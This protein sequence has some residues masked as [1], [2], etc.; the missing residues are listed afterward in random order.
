MKGIFIVLA[1]CWSQLVSAQPAYFGG[2]NSTNVTVTAS[3]SFQDPNWPKSA[4]PQ[5][6][7]NAQGMLAAYFNAA[8][9]LHQTTLGFDSTHVLEVLNLGFTGWINDQ[10]NK[11]IEK[12][13][14]R[15]LNIFDIIA[16]T[17]T[18][19]GL[20][21]EIGRRPGWKE[22]NYAWWDVNMQNNDLLRQRVAAALSEILVISRNSDLE[23]YG[24]GLASFYDILL[25]HAF[26]NYRD[27]LYDVTLH[28]AMGFYLSHLDNPKTDESTGT[29]PDENYARE[30]MQ[31]FSIGLYQLNIDGTRVV[32]NGSE[33]PTY[34]NDDISEFAKVF[35][36][37]GVGDLK[38]DIA[39]YN[40]TAAFGI[41]IYEADMTVPMR[42]YDVDDPGTSWRDED[43]HEEGPK[44]LLNN[45]TVPDGQTGL[46]DINDAI[47]NLFNHSN[48]GPFLAYRLIQRLV[49]S[50]PTPAYVQ[51]VASAFNGTGP[52]GTVR[53]D[54]KS[55]VKAILLDT[56]ARDA[57]WQLDD[58][59]GKL[60]E[61]LIRYTHFARAVEKYNANGFYWNIGYGF[62]E[63]TKQA[64]LASPSVFNFF[65]P[66]DTPNGD[67]ADQGL[68]A[69]EF[70]I[71]D[72]RTS[73]GFANNVYVWAA[74]W[75][76][77]MGT[78]EGEIMTH[79]DVDWVIDDLLEL[80][81]D[82][83]SYIN[84]LDK[85]LH[86]GLMSDRTRGILRNA[87]NSFKS[88][89][90]WHNYQENRVRMG[91][92]LALMAPEYSIMR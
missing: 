35:T 25:E 8:R 40:D 27:L 1:I 55:V 72:S 75:G 26:G 33:V 85:H 17:L 44:Y 87:L 3:S 88:T 15:T 9:F 4:I 31:L 6:T 91:L 22:F 39:M 67:I 12:M 54:M 71:H 11:P 61:P 48:V 68:V 23:G 86:S 70:K 7:V 24:D 34:D 84:W 65:L 47:D 92:H 76:R 13:L 49:K 60:K 46:E 59:N 37:L 79:T 28:P 16:D 29:H 64:I 73:V 14:P 62:Y 50:N 51:R 38:H 69:P 80:A 30:V 10:F 83:E 5:N 43:Q 19:Q 66:D 36:G 45:F 58:M 21:S 89:V 57:S 20:G 81:K 77:I 82:S 56:E 2:G 53:G 52:Y 90:S 32:Q 18:S 74:S 63:D 78:W 42:M 41:G